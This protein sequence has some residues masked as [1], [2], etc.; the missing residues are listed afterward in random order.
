MNIIED[1]KE[2]VTMLEVLE[3]YGQ[4]PVRG[5]NNYKCFVHDDKRPS[6][7]LTKSGDKFHCFACGYT[8]NILDVVQH[9]EKCD[10]KTAMKILDS[11]FKLGLYKQLTHKE[12]LELAKQMKERER[13][14]QEKLWWKRF[15]S[16][17][18]EVIIEEMREFE[19]LERI[20]RIDKGMYR[21][22]WSIE[23][24]DTYFY[25]LKGL[26][27]LEWLYAV[28]TE[29]PHPECE[30]DYIY[31]SDKTTLLKMIKDG[32]IQI[33]PESAFYDTKDTFATNLSK[34]RQ[35]AI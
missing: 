18:L 5:R 14:R 4:Y 23:F 12:K 30:Y 3:L 34:Q 24:G 26:K 27:W 29:T 1:L 22:Q 17:V 7:G 32:D 10:L 35:T 33:P 28:V 11:K 15:E 2:R 8:G 9:F 25:V 13:E 21:G 31:P 6:A 19:E 20:F 16:V